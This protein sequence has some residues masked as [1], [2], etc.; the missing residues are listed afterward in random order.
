MYVTIMN[1]YIDPLRMQLIL[2]LVIW[3]MIWKGVALWKA[4]QN[5]DKWWFIAIFI[6]N[7][8]GTLPLVYILFFSKK[9]SK[10]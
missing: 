1:M 9:L 7:T 2:I 3:E 10:K 6:A 8:V 5:K 4:S